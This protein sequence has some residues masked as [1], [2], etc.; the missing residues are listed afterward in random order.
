MPAKPE[1]MLPYSVKLHRSARTGRP[2]NPGAKHFQTPEITKPLVS[3]ET[4]GFVYIEFGGEGE[5]RKYPFALCETKP[6]RFI[7]A[8]ARY[9]LPITKISFSQPSPEK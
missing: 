5:M 1:A 2:G 8:A 6:P 4:R 3:F 9:D 7:R